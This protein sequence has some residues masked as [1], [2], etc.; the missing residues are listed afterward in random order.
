M[1]WITTVA[2][3]S[4][5]MPRKLQK[6]KTKQIRKMIL[7]TP[8]LAKFPLLRVALSWKVH[9]PPLQK[10]KQT[11]LPAGGPDTWVNRWGPGG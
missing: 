8:S 3:I 11:P 6:A 2:S 1:Y 7:E 4:V 10:Q 5:D 9:L